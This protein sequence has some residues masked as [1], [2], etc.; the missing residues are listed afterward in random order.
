MRGESVW[1]ECHRRRI[2]RFKCGFYISS[3]CILFSIC[4]PDLLTLMDLELSFVS[5]LPV[6]FD[7][8]ILLAAKGFT[9]TL[10]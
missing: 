4:F 8:D 1:V 7:N 6:V 10:G 9:S 3:N 2:C 5:V